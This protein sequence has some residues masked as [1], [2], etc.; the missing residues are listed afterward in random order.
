MKETSRI[1][2]VKFW[3]FEKF[4]GLPISKCGQLNSLFRAFWVDSVFRSLYQAFLLVYLLGWWDNTIAHSNNLKCINHYRNCTS[5]TFCVFKQQ[6]IQLQFFTTLITQLILNFSYLKCF[7]GEKVRSYQILDE[8][9][10]A[11]CVEITKRYMHE[12]DDILNNFSNC[13]C[14]SDIM[15]SRMFI[16]DKFMMS[17]ECI[18]NT[19]W[20]LWVWY[21]LVSDFIHFRI[22]QIYRIFSVI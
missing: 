7:F 5:K 6:F 15:H 13:S 19:L 3:D 1:K 20:Y 10:N 18:I 9:R 12:Y 17:K 4:L 11:E 2:L 14:Y 21:L 22:K 16:S 8:F